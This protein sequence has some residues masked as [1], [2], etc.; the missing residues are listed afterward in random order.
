MMMI[1]SSSR[2]ES[3]NFLDPGGNCFEVPLLLLF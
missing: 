3:E 1:I 2:L